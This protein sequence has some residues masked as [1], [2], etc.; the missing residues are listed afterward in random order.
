MKKFLFFSLTI[1]T[2]IM[3]ASCE[4]AAINNSPYDPPPVSPE[5]KTAVSVEKA[6][7]VASHFIASQAQS[8]TKNSEISV[9]NIDEIKSDNGR[10]LMYIINYAP[11]G[12]VIV[13]ATKDYYPILAFSDKGNYSVE[14][15]EIANHI[16]LDKTKIAVTQSADLS[17]SIKLGM[18]TLWS[19]YSEGVAA[20]A[21]GNAVTKAPGWDELSPME[22]VFQLRIAELQ[23]ELG[24]GFHF[25]RLSDIFELGEFPDDYGAYLHYCQMARDVESPLE[26]TIVGISGGTIANTVGPLITTQWQQEAGFNTLCDNPPGEP[27]GCAPIAIA[28]IMKFHEYPTTYDWDQMHNTAATT[29]SRILIRD[30][31]RQTGQSAT[32][33]E[34]EDAVQHFGYNTSMQGYNEQVLIDEIQSNHQPVLM[35]GILSTSN[36]LGHAW[37]CD[38]IQDIHSASGYFIDF[39]VGGEYTSLEFAPSKEDM[40]I[41]SSPIYEYFHINW[42]WGPYDANANAWYLPDD[43]FSTTYGDFSKDNMSLFI[44]KP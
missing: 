37:V 33:D 30:I 18:R 17:D 20:K 5:I 44:Y 40:I 34:I 16:W 24:D 1:V 39:Y 31:Q 9:K 4:K 21:N 43:A 26:Y 13:S 15:S 6:Q 29:A 42:G 27:A 11:E 38:G 7:S 12:F 14:K 32:E 22:Q 19:S 2:A 3:L 35:T 28:Q 8:F 41:A 23:A 10:T 25:H 36:S